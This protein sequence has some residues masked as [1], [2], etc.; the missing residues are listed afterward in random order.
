[1]ADQ[2]GLVFAYRIDDEG[3]SRPIG[4]EELSATDKGEGWLWIHLDRSAPQAR[5]WLAEESGI[6]PLIVSEALLD[7]ET[8]PRFTAT[9]DG[10]LLILRGVNLNPGADP[11]D[12]V[13]I[14]LWIEAERVISV[15]QRRLLAV[16]DLRQ[17]MEEAN[18]PKTP[19]EL[20]ANLADGLVDRMSD[21]ISNLNDRLDD[22]EDEVVSTQRSELRGELNALR[23]EGIILR[24]YIAPQRDALSRLTSAKPSLLKKSH[25]TR[26]G[27]VADDITR[28]V[29][30]LDAARERAAVVQDELM[31]R[32]SEQLNKNMYVLS[33]IAGIF[34][35]LGFIVGLLGVNVDGIPGEK[36]PWA[37]AALCVLMV[38]L[39]VFEVWLF[40]RFRWI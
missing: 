28:H 20:V 7:E 36:T 22:L 16:D 9:E 5:K 12:M 19:G 21:V 31:N 29:E 3:K 8:R 17:A 25:L 11:E 32:L 14:R 39:G 23:R 4:W 40:R 24:R 27:E 18:G 38:G 34:L 26:L 2:N 33:I 10:L 37:F 30:N 1:M 6:D 15:R 35:P 13:S